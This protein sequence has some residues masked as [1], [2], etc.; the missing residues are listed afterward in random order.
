MKFHAITNKYGTAPEPIVKFERCEKNFTIPSM[1]ATNGTSITTNETSIATN[2]TLIAT[3][4]TSSRLNSLDIHRSLDNIK[5]QDHDDVSSPLVER[6]LPDS[7]CGTADINQKFRQPRKILCIQK[8]IVELR[9]AARC[10]G[11]ATSCPNLVRCQENKRLFHH[12]IRCKKREE[13]DVDHCFLSKR[14]LHHYHYCNDQRC[15]ICTPIKTALRRN[16]HLRLH[17]KKNLNS[18]VEKKQYKSPESKSLQK[19]HRSVTFAPGC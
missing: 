16:A 6:N 12:I 5:D 9:H 17:K 7:L 19:P 13:C 10:T 15:P 2:E 3:N 4:E 11:C 14:I 8:R 1:I 18:R